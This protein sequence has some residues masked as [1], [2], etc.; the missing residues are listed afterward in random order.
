[1]YVSQRQYHAKDFSISPDQKYVLLIYD[2]K[3]VSTETY[4]RIKLVL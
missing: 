2:V 3:K 1:M 4:A